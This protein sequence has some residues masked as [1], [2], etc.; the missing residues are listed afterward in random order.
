VSRGG[1]EGKNERMNKKMKELMNERYQC[2]KNEKKE[3][4]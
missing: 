3:H 1:Q 4:G 2:D